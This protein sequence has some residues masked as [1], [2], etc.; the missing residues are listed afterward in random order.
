MEWKSPVSPTAG[1]PTL[2]I[3]SITGA[4]FLLSLSDA[5][6]KVAGDHVGLGQLVLIRSA[7]AAI[8]IAGAV[9]ATSGLDRLRPVRPGWVWLRSLCLTGMWLCYYA[10]LPAMSFALAAACYYT[11]PIWMA[12]LSRL[13][14]KEPLGRRRWSAVAIGLAGVLIAINPG[15]ETVSP[16]VALPLAAAFLYA[17]AGIIT[18]SR[19][20]EESA[21]AMAQTLN[22]SLIVGGALAISV[23]AL[24][25]PMPEKNFV[26]T[27]WPPLGLDDWL[28]IAAL[29]V[30]LAAIEIAVAI[31][32]R[33][34]PP[35]I[36][37]VFDNT[38]L[39]FAALWG[40]LLF[41]DI[42]SVR[43][44]SGMAL[45]AAGAL[46]AS[47]RPPAKEKGRCLEGHRPR[48]NAGRG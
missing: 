12:V 8:L 3:L 28:F 24:A 45:I 32:Y 18:W 22:A 35:D 36:I 31:A 16:V 34:G 19:C 40:A 46:M 6:V 30:L 38:Y 26:L 11:A 10:A 33:L 27:V 41:A 23:L 29:G 48:P 47:R 44:G 20:R 14:L 15:A 7:F 25:G 42:P 39:L 13:V 43:E 4:V 2:G 1:H 37:G 5:L 9:A 21:L 17:L